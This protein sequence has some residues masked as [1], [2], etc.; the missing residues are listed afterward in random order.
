MVN[1][2]SEEKKNKFVRYFTIIV[3]VLSIVFNIGYT[4]NELDHKMDESAAKEIIDNK[5]DKKIETIKQEIKDRYVK[6]EDGSAI[7]QRLKGIEEKLMKQEELIFKIYDRLI[8]Q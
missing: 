4:T 1:R 2:M 6:I 3:F 7:E 8:K 5:V